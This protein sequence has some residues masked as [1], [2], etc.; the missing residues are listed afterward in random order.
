MVTKNHK[1]SMAHNNNFLLLTF[2]GWVRAGGDG[3]AL[4]ILAGLAVISGAN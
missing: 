1:T 2:Q 3:T 4:L